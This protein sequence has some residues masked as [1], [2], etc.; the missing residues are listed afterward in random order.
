MQNLIPFQFE[1][2]S[3]RVVTDDCGEPLFVGKDICDALGYQRHSDAMQAHCKGSA[4]YR[5]LQT[6]GGV[7][8]VRVLSEPDVLRLIISCNLPAA[9]KFERWVFEDVLP[10]IRK[11]GSYTPPSAAPV[12]PVP[13]VLTQAIEQSLEMVHGSLDANFSEYMSLRK[14]INDFYSQLPQRLDGICKLLLAEH[15]ADIKGFG[16]MFDSMERR[17]DALEK[18][19]ARIEQRLD[20]LED[21]IAA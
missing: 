7:Q 8:E 1:N 20:R 3:I 10:T 13:A 16:L 6:A 19:V 18:L 14:E 21:R 5:P 12:A 9:D 11:T 2:Q 4:I 17:F 15:A